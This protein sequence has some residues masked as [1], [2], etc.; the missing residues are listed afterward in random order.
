MKIKIERELIDILNDDN[1]HQ[2]ENIR[3]LINDELIIS[4]LFYDKHKHLSIHT[5]K[6]NDRLNI[7]NI[8][9]GGCLP[10]EKIVEIIEMVFDLYQKEDKND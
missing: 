1:N 8:E 9:T 5:G 4:I 6:W 10:N 2:T 3:Y 7:L